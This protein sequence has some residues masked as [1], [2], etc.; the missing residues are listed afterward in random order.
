MKLCKNCR[1]LIIGEAASQSFQNLEKL[2][3]FHGFTPK[4]IPDVALPLGPMCEKCLKA[5]SKEL[6]SA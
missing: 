5:W 1:S 6:T 3:T 4:T 2:L